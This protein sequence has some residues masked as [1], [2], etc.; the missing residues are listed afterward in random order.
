MEIV[1]RLRQELS[2]LLD[3]IQCAGGGIVFEEYP[4]ALEEDPN[5]ANALG[6]DISKACHALIQEVNEL[7]EVLAQFRSGI[8]RS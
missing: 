6:G 4:G 2:G 8:L 3:A 7:A 1:E 5:G